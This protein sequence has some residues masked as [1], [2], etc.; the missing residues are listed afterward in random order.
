MDS[1]MFNSNTFIHMV[2]IIPLDRDE[3]P[4]IHSGI[5]PPCYYP[6]LR[7]RFSSITWY[8]THRSTCICV[9]GY[10]PYFDID[11]QCIFW[12]LRSLLVMESW[13]HIVS[14]SAHDLTHCLMHGSAVYL[15][16]L[17]LLTEHRYAFLKDIRLRWFDC[18][19][20]LITSAHPGHPQL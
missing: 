5:T 14:L 10:V 8:L 17:C 18:C 7:W 16:Q 9:Y 12:W 20:L 4:R 6:R 11:P 1:S 15:R 19:C 13:F 3:D 2:W